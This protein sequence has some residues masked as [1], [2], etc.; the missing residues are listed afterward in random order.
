MAARPSSR[1]G[2][3]WLARGLQQ[4]WQRRRLSCLLWPLSLL[5]RVLVAGRRKLYARGLLA[6]EHAAAVTVVVGNVVAG[7]AGKTPVVIAVVE[8]LQARG[9]KVGVVSR[10]HGRTS[11]S[12]LEVHA[13]SHADEV[14][15]EPLLIRRRTGAPVFVATRRLDAAHALLKAHPDTRVLVCDDGLQH[16]AL[17]RDV[18]ICVFDDRGI[19]NGFLQPA[20][21]LREPWPRP[22]D[23]ILHSGSR[24]AMDSGYRSERRLADTARNGLGQSRPLQAFRGQPVQA[25]A[26]I[27]WPERFFAMLREQGLELASTLALPDHHDFADWQTLDGGGVAVLCTEKDAAKLWRHEPGAWAVPLECAPEK[28]FWSALDARLAPALSSAAPPDSH[29]NTA[30]HGQQ[31]T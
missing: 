14:G 13:D 25:V 20:G 28:A 1:A 16:L 11:R 24:P 30:S 7:G 21:P 4:A 19:G 22:V 27:A 29:P 5:F 31:A 3:R 12:T 26:G 18:E 6:S 15:D 2:Q 8:H 10:G 23:L 9:L 17:Q